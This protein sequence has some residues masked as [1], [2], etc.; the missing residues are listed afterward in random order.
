MGIISEMNFDT[1]VRHDKNHVMKPNL[2]IHV[3]KIQHTFH[4]NKQRTCKFSLVKFF[5]H[6]KGSHNKPM[7]V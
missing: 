7:P 1:V 3:Y 2:K 5:E 4:E 6:K